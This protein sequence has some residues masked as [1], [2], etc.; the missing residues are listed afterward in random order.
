MA[1]K[2]HHHRT[3]KKINTILIYL[4]NWKKT[5]G[6][7]LHKGPSFAVKLDEIEREKDN[8]NIGSTFSC[9]HT[10]PSPTCCSSS[11]VR[12]ENFSNEDWCGI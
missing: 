1:A 12:K 7:L 4:V 9:A 2:Q 3:F 5:K 6:Q 8:I 10:L 11:D